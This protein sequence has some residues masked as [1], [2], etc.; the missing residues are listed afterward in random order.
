MK[1]TN[2]YDAFKLG[3]K[4]AITAPSEKDMVKTM[5]LVYALQNNLSKHQINSAQK[6]V[7]KELANEI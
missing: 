4:L 3:L 5:K 6:E 1:L 7:E 2:D